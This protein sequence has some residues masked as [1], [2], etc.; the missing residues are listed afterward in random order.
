MPA[1]LPWDS[2]HEISSQG[3]MKKGAEKNALLCF[4]LGDTTGT[5]LCWLCKQWES[6]ECILRVWVKDYSLHCIWLGVVGESGRILEALHLERA[7]IND[8]NSHHS[9]MKDA[10]LEHFPLDFVVLDASLTTQ[11]LLESLRCVWKRDIQELQTG[12]GW[13]CLWGSWTQG[14]K[15]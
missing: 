2:P 10:K 8:N 13:N 12:Q 4:C 1:V 6:K 5:Y 15:L 7:R 11:F 9:M 3:T 14:L